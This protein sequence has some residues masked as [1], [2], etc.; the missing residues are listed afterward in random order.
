MNNSAANLNLFYFPLNIAVV[1]DDKA[2]LKIITSNL[3]NA[4]ISTYNSTSEISIKINPIDVLL[5]IANMRM[6]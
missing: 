4:T 5:K 1:D 6:E 2:F 3:P